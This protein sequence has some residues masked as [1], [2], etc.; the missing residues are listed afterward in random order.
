MPRTRSV[1]EVEVLEQA[2]RVF[3][4]KGYDRASVADICKATGL[5]PSSIYNA[6]GSK[7][8]L[9]RQTLKHY[10]DTY[11]SPVMKC[12]DDSIPASRSLHELLREYVNL[13]FEPETPPGSYLMQSGGTGVS[14]NS[15]AC[16]ITNE[17]KQSIANVIQRMLETRQQAGDQLSAPP[18]TLAI[19]LVMTARGLSQLACDGYSPDDLII[20]AD[21][22][23]KSC[24][25]D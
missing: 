22:A 23:S 21:H 3:W 20:V 8:E 11:G 7:L 17:T 19:F 25:L 6:F 1:P 5:G 10:M 15:E 2:M 16:A 18:R 14:Q 4:A 9:Y 12:M 13:I 24:V